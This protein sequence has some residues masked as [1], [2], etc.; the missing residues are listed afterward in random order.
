M[1]THYLEL[2][3]RSL[4]AHRGLTVLMLLSMALGVAAC[5]T[6]LTVF[7]VLSGDP[8]PEK[9]GRLFNVQLDA[10]SKEGFQPGGEPTLQLT[11]FD[12]EALLRDKRAVHQVMM[13]GANIAVDPEGSSP[14]GGTVQQPFF[15]PARYAS[16]DFFAVFD[17]P[18]AF[19]R[20]WSDSDDANEARVV[21][22]S[23]RL[24]EQLF[25]GADSRGRTVRLR[26]KDFTVVGVLRPWRPAPHYFDLTLGAYAE[27]A[28]VY[29]PLATSYALKLGGSGS[30]NCWG[31]NNQDPRALGA[32]CSFLQYWVQLDTEQQRR[33]Y[34][35]YLV[36]YSDQQREA[37][38]FE[39]PAN[40]R[41]RP[42]MEW[43]TVRKVVPS[44]FRL[45]VWLAFGFLVVCLTNTVGLLLAK[46]LRRSGEI[47]V[48]R[49]LGAPRR[50]IFLQ[51]LVEA[52]SLGLAG[53]LL[54]L[55]MTWAALWIV[56]M[57]PAPYA[58][59]ARMDWQMLGLTVLLSLVASLLAGLLPAWRACQVTPAL[60]LKSQ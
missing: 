15:A 12:A 24:N 31:S 10:E 38:R 39:R 26:D 34:F 50:Q 53:G 21:V 25:G 27:A 54:G 37:G 14:A 28:D 23:H 8:I 48:R 55:L 32:S 18:F 30:M 1:L 7:H 13:T 40:P 44:D 20:G 59:L 29:L 45:Q 36:Q 49:A 41:L 58:A 4:R 43:L 56:R 52:G 47:A 2:G 17:A 33:D 11:R 5:M 51:F 22:I 19:G 35:D 42:V 3:L 60:Q 9:S 6:T 57:N 16:A 46:C